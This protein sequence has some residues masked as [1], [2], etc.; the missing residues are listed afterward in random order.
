ME[1][2]YGAGVASKGKTSV[3]RVNGQTGS[4][5]EIFI[6]GCLLHWMELS[7]YVYLIR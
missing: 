7:V 2:R 3:N 4:T 1:G 6:T 5:A